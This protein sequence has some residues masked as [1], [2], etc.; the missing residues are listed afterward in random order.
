MLVEHYIYYHLHFPEKSLKKFLKMQSH[1]NGLIC[2]CH[3]Y[4]IIFSDHVTRPIVI[5]GP[6]S[7]AVLDKLISDYPNKFARCEPEYMNCDQEA[8]EKAGLN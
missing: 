8:L 6:L 1:L 2:C 4:Q 3:H 5:V 7:E